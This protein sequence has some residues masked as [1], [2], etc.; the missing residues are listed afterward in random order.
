MLNN[1]RVTCQQIWGISYGMNN[2]WT[3]IRIPSCTPPIYPLLL[4]CGYWWSHVC[5]VPS[6]SSLGGLSW[7]GYGR[8]W[9]LVAMA[10]QGCL[11][12]QPNHW[13]SGWVLAPK[14]TPI[15]VPQIRPGRR[16]EEVLAP[17]PTCGTGKLMLRHR[18]PDLFGHFGD[19]SWPQLRIT[20]PFSERHG[21]VSTQ[22]F[23]PHGH[24]IL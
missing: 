16:W 5:C 4:V 11:Q 21:I 23:D 14:M 20:P 12:C 15:L 3:V 7:I 2:Y 18:L 6:Y 19:I 24:R 13:G 22:N 8:L 17:N 10:L 9:V 1:Q